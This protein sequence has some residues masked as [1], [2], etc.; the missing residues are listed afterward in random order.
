MCANSSQICLPTPGLSLG[1]QIHILIVCVHHLPGVLQA[2]NVNYVHHAAPVDFI[3][4]YGPSNQPG[5]RQ[6]T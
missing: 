1:S 5:I 2:L 4:E 3:L 6:E